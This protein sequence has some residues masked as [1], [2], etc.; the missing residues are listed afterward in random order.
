MRAITVDE[1]LLYLM[2][3]NMWINI[4]LSQPILISNLWSP[5]LSEPASPKTNGKSIPS[6]K[7]K[8]LHILLKLEDYEN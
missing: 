7:K 3:K 1:I 8:L 4:Y 2:V 6:P 5:A